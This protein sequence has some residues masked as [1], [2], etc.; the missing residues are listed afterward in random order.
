MGTQGLPSSRTEKRARLDF[1]CADSAETKLSEDAQFGDSPVIA[2]VNSPESFETALLAPTRTLYIL[3]GNPLTLP[4]LL[5]RARDCGKLCLVNM[6]F[7]DGLA[8]DR[9]AVEFLAASGAAGIVSTRFESLKAAR[10]LGLVT[11]QRT[12]AIDTAAVTA[13]KKSLTQ[14][15]PNAIEVLPAMVAP[16]VGKELREAHPNLTIIGGGLIESVREIE[17]LLSAGVDAITTSNP[18]LW[19]I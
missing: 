17:E 10:N 2:S 7:L 11:V 1:Y 4:T 6:D 14:F 15:F 3:T 12:F 9:F 5:K 8:R 13:S 18:R 19:L 16:R